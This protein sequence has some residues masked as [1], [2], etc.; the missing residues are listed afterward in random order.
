MSLQIA[1]VILARK[2]IH[3]NQ[4]EVYPRNFQIWFS[5]KQNLTFVGRLIP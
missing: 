5:Y 1:S 4:I 3:S 2:I